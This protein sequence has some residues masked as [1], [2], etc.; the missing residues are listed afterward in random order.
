[1]TLTIDANVVWKP[2]NIFRTVAEKGVV[3]NVDDTRE[4]EKVRVVLMRVLS[5]FPDACQAVIAALEEL[6]GEPWRPFPEVGT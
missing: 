3:A 6:G 2:R 4:L 1:M 5:R